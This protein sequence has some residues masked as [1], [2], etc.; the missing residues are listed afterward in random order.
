MKEIFKLAT[1]KGILKHVE[2]AYE[3]VE[4]ILPGFFEEWKAANLGV[5]IH[6]LQKDHRLL[7][8][9]IP[10]TSG[11]HVWE[12]WA[13]NNERV[14]WEEIDVITASQEEVLLHALKLI[15]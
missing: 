14:L 5:I 13:W 7:V 10:R 15:K 12:L 2:G 6:K 8:C 3:D 11:K 4:R 9:Q 1:E